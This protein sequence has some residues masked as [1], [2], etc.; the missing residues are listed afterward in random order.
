[1]SLWLWWLSSC[2]VQVVT[3]Q[4]IVVVDVVDDVDVDSTNATITTTANTTTTDSPTSTPVATASTLSPSSLTDADT[5][6][7][8]FSPSSSSTDAASTTNS[9]GISDEEDDDEILPSLINVEDYTN[10]CVATDDSQTLRN[11]FRVYGGIFLIIVV[12]FL[13][14]RARYPQTYSIRSW[15]NYPTKLASSTSGSG[16]IEFITNLVKLSDEQLQDECGMDSTCLI[17]VNYFG[18]KICGFCMLLAIVL[19]PVYG[20]ANSSKYTDCIT[21]TIQSISISHVPQNSKLLL[22]STISCYF[23]FG[24]IMYSILVELEWLRTVRS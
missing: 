3:A 20:T 17:R 21:D 18:L 12:L 22:V 8:T 13:F 7:S 16:F 23:I 10:A 24:F 11:T 19:M 6:G 5:S 14:L 15:G 4:E 1:M 9:S 2:S